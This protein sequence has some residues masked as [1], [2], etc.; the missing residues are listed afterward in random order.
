M[1]LREQALAV[2]DELARCMSSKSLGQERLDWPTGQTT[3]RTMGKGRD[4]AE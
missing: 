4:S 1:V 3:E 2:C